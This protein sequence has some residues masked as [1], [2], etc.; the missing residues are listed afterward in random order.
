VKAVDRAGYLAYAKTQ[1]FVRQLDSA[2]RKISR[3]LELSSSPFVSFSA[4]KDSSAM[5]WLVWE[6]RPDIHALALL[7]PESYMLHR[8]LGQVLEWWRQQWPASTLLDVLLDPQAE[9]WKEG[10]DKTRHKWSFLHSRGD[11]D[12]VFVGLRAEE[13]DNRRRAFRRFRIPGEPRGFYRYSENRTDAQAGRYRFAPL[14]DWREHDVGAL[15]ALHDIA[16]LEAYTIEGM[17]ARTALRTG[18]GPLRN[19]QLDQL[20]NR[21]PQGWA[22]LIR[23]WPDVE[24]WANNA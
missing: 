24:D 21:D 10:Y 15:L 16:L 23:M 6:Q 5:L 17:G 11:Y 22:N 19:G 2:R 18:K 9:T 1:G 8:D 4:G 13:S 20:R 3:A 14:C 12:G 7:G